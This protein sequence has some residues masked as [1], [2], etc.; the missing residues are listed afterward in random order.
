MKRIGTKKIIREQLFHLLYEEDLGADLG[1]EGE[2]D[3]EKEKEKK[4]IEQT[5]HDEID[6][7]I[8]RTFFRLK[9]DSE[10]IR[11]YRTLYQKLDSDN[12]RTMNDFYKKLLDDLKAMYKQQW[13]LTGID[14]SILDLFPDLLQTINNE[15]EKAYINIKDRVTKS[16]VFK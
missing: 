8:R 2:V 10:V 13:K 1:I 16:G 7:V 14:N 5:R 11:R 4:K 6:D 12:D 9:N 15:F 3:A